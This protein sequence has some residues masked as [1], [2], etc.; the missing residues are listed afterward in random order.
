MAA[1]ARRWTPPGTW[2]GETIL[3]R[4]RE[5][6]NLYGPPTSY[7]WSLNV[8]TLVAA[9]LPTAGRRRW[10]RQRPHWP[11]TKA[12]I[13]YH[14]S[15]T[16]ALARAGLDVRERRYDRPLEDRVAAAHCMRAAGETTA[17]IAAALGVC[18]RTAQNYLR[19]S[20]CEECGQHLVVSPVAERCPSCDHARR[21]RWT[22]EEVV[23]ALRRWTRTFGRAPLARQWEP[24]QADGR[25][26]DAQPPYP[27]ATT[28]RH[29]CGSW[30]AAREAAGLP[31]LR[32]VRP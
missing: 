25:W 28:V 29:V 30:A 6:T 15:W 21:P 8:D 2:D 4:I 1:A 32:Q 5:W 7:E 24:K 26:R 19:A 14:G 27:S 22:R 20:L 18:E 23:E 13:S 10:Q 11:S 12:V 9:G 16:T 31:V 17:A 3:E